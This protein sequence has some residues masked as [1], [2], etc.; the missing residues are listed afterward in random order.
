MRKQAGIYTN[1]AVTT[2]AVYVPQDGL[3]G[4]AEALAV[5][6]THAGSKAVVPIDTSR[7]SMMGGSVRCMCWQLQPED[8]TAKRLLARA[9]AER[10]A[11]QHA[12][13]LMAMEEPEGAAAGQGTDKAAK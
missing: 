4:A 12:A 5:V 6:T 2:N 9:E 3:P 7:V 13:E 11:S 8:D 10:A 1:S